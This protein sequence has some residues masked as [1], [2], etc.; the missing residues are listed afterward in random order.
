MALFARAAKLGLGPTARGTL[1]LSGARHARAK[2]TDMRCI[3]R[4]RNSGIKPSRINIVAQDLT[5]SLP[6]FLP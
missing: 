1:G 4:Q 2:P 5:N 6:R 3:R